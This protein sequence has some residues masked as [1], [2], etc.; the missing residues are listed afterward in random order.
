MAS[1]YS[2]QAPD[3]ECDGCANA[4]RNSLGKL[5][6]VSSVAVDVDS[7]KVD[8]AYDPAEVNEAAIDDRLTNAGFPPARS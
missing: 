7:K 1:H 5:K 2:A 3:I 8:V 4:I 6:G